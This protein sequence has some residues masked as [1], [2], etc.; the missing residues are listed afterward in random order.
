MLTLE[1]SIF[2]AL[3]MKKISSRNTHMPVNQK[4]ELHHVR[5]FAE[6]ECKEREDPDL[7]LP[8]SCS[9]ESNVKFK[10]TFLII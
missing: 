10:D 3:F 9:S 7:H 8:F 2:F 5:F 4:Q 1:I 6:M